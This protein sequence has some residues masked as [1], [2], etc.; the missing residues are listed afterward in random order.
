VE[1]SVL[2]KQTWR[3]H[4]SDDVPFSALYCW[5]S[6]V[7]IGADA[8]TKDAKRKCWLDEGHCSTTGWYWLGVIVVWIC[9]QFII[10]RTAWHLFSLSYLIGKQAMG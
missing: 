4:F 5:N 2:D 9:D 6:Y 7:D 3:T 8:R 1:V 10:Q